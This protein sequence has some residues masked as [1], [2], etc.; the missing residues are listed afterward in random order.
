M[1][2][3]AYACSS[4]GHRFDIY[5]AFTDDALTECP[6][7]G[8]PLRKEF[9]NVG[10]VFKGSGFYRNDARK[11]SPTESTGSSSGAKDSSGS[12]DSSASKDSGSSTSTS[13]D[14]GSSS[15]GSTSSTSSTSKAAG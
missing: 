6:E 14:S 3:Y 1:P 11:G 10:V 7:C 9:G 2:T 13:K 12:K 15:S 5:Q 4:C 8:G